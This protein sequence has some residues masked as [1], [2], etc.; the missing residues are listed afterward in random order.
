MIFITLK[1]LAAKCLY[2]DAKDYQCRIQIEQRVIE[3]ELVE[4]P[5]GQKVPKKERITICEDIATGT[6]YNE[7]DEDRD[8]EIGDIR[9]EV[10]VCTVVFE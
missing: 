6:P 8:F 3:G 9:E 7:N 4:V 5:V 1:A 10:V 2:L